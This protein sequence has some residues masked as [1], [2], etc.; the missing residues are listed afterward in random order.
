LRAPV[1]GDKRGVLKTAEGRGRTRHGMCIASVDPGKCIYARRR[2]MGR[3]ATWRCNC[4]HTLGF[5]YLVVVSRR[6]LAL[7][8]GHPLR[9]ADGVFRGSVRG[10]RKAEQE[11]DKGGSLERSKAGVYGSAMHYRLIETDKEHPSALTYGFVAG[12]N[13]TSQAK[14][15]KLS[16]L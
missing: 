13:M 9:K 15:R 14:L 3:F 16:R 8:I 10:M 6:H 1:R 2:G 11:L 7:P 4:C 12:R 5:P